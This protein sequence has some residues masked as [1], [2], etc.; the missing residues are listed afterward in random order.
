MSATWAKA[1]SRSV[2][3]LALVGTVV[4]AV[5]ALVTFDRAE[6]GQI[7]VVPARLE[8]DVAEAAALLDDQCSGPAG[9]PS[10]GDAAPVY[11]RVVQRRD[12]GATFLVGTNFGGLAA[13][14][15][16]GLLW[17]LTGMV[18]VS[19]QPN[20][21]A[22]WVLQLVGVALITQ[23]LGAGLV[24]AGVKAAPGSIPLMG[25]L[26]MVGEHSFVIIFLLPL[27][28]LYFPD[29]RPPSARWRWPV[30]VYFA[31]VAVALLAAV[32]DPGPLNNFVEMGIVYLNPLGVSWL[33]G[34]SGALQAVGV[35]TALLITVATVFGVRGRYE[36]AAGDER[37]Q[38][39]W[40]RLV[41]TMTVGSAIVMFVG[42]AVIELLFGR[43]SPYEWWWPVWFGVAAIAAGVGVP[44][45]YFIAIFKHGLWGLDLIV[46]K[47]VQYLVVLAAMAIVA[48]VVVVAVP[49]LVLGTAVDAGFWAVVALAAL[50]AA[51]FSWLLGPARRIAAR[52]VYGR[53]ASP[54]EVLADFGVQVGGA[55]SMD[56]VLPK[57]AQLVA[58]AT[59]ARR[60]DIWLR[61]GTLLRSEA[62]YPPGAPAPPPRPADEVAPNHTEFVVDVVHE[63]R[64]LGAI[65]VEQPPDD[66]MNPMREGL[67]RGL[68]A[69]AGLVL[70][71]VS[72][73]ADVRASRQRLVV[74][75]D[76]ERRRIERNLHDGAQQQ[77]VAL[78]VQLRLV[79][80]L[81]E[82]D[83]VKA[84][85]MVD[86]VAQVAGE[87]L[88]DLRDLARGIY[89]PV[90]ADQG[91]GA[92]LE[93]Q[94]RKAAVPTT[95]DTDG[96]GRYA[97]EIEAAV[98]FCI[99]EALNN[100]AKYAGASRA[101]ILVSERDGHLSFS[102]TDD[103]RGFE[104]DA[105]RHGT[106]LQGMVDRMEAVGG[107]ID[108]R[109]ATGEGTTVEGRVPAQ[110]RS[111][112]EV[113]ALA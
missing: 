3:A 98:Y 106:G 103:G 100:V 6:P 87:A 21:A 104:P 109:T 65:S 89:P 54:Y 4:T 18:I 13:I 16:V 74:A 60:V 86:S 95:L 45:A 92:A 63:G 67:L 7:V 78:S 59:G 1:I 40:L 9:D 49:A 33:A 82:R 81:I 50:L 41:T 72:L 29:G 5:V 70:R 61:V 17:L 97:P 12:A 44:T 2:V 38:L 55:Y 15:V 77:L 35:I 24:F 93:A 51:A 37:Q 64:S 75:Q 96:I 42:G 31:G 101:T 22:G 76:D 48:V 27:L 32:L 57:M 43:D 28:W 39:R 105:A 107:R 85:E 46:K 68:A 20:N 8:E 91:L 71:N 62:R 79:R 73:L 94:A 108:L 112:D 88:E 56:D 99:L 14:L 111:D 53:R 47:T 113:A 52:I 11:C 83:P 25:M 34:I 26:A 10:L 90:L 23:F 30:R 36:R 84:A 102:V 19:R 69:Q 110:A 66:P 80:S 58:E